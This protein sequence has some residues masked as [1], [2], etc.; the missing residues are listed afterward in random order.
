MGS[1]R[2]GYGIEYYASGTVW[3]C[4]CIRDIP[5]LVSIR[6]AAGIAMPLGM[7]GVIAKGWGWVSMPAWTFFI[8]IF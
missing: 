7:V 8:I 6:A 2:L 4:S 3:M 1:S 5:G